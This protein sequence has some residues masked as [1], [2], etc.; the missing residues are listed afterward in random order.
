MAHIEGRNILREVD[1]AKV[2]E[3]KVT[4]SNVSNTC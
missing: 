3:I 1:D 2:W 4:L